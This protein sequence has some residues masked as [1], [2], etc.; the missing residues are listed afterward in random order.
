MKIR[1][2]CVLC[3]AA[4][5]LGACSSESSTSAQKSDS[6]AESEKQALAD[7]KAKE[8]RAAARAQK[9]KSLTDASNALVL[10]PGAIDR[11]LKPEGPSAIEI[12]WD[13]TAFGTEGVHVFLQNPGEEKKLWS[14][15]GAIGSDKT[16]EWMNDGAKVILVNGVNDEVISSLELRGAPCE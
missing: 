2:L 8:E 12:S 13:A 15:S 5:L 16:G 7:E 3:A 4:V 14:T 10:R 6:A 9:I 11:C 1:T